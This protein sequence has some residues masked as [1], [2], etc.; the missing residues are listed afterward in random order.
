MVLMAL[1]HASFFI[2]KIHSR[3]FWGAPLPHFP[4]A[5]A[6]LTRAVTHL[7]A[8]GFFMLMGIGM[9]LLAT[10]LRNSGGTETRIMRHFLS[11]GIG[12]IVIQQLLENPAW[13]IGLFS[14]DIPIE[15]YTP[16]EIPGSGDSLIFVFGV[17][18]SL[19]TA[20]MF[21]GLL[22]RFNGYIIA[23]I[24]I[25]AVFGIQFVNLAPDDVN[26]PYN[27]VIRLL[28]IPGIT[29][30]WMVLYSVFPWAGIAGIGIVLGRMLERNPIRTYRTAAVLGITLIVAFVFIR[31]GDAFGNFHKISGPGWIPFLN[32]TKYPPSLTYICLTVGI[33]L[34]LLY[35]IYISRTP[36]EKWARPLLIFG[37]TPLF[38]YLAHLYVYAAMGLAF[39][40]GTN[41]IQLYPL[42]LLGLAILY[43]LCRGYEAWRK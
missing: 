13:L 14:S 7:C 19:G 11:R 34:V 20:L 35:L 4:D 25:A 26:I 5:L 8:P 41:L 6:F 18:F 38:F 23:T 22:M 39:P 42:W 15:H 9:T 12:L 17:L 32:V 40:R 29:G 43:P 28:A 10:K 1:D 30:H 37:R 3:E 33:N 31:S 24:S 2:A 21:W 16:A 36:I 27:P